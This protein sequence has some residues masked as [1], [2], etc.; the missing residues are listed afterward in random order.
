MLR[1][2][3]CTGVRPAARATGGYRRVAG[4]GAAREQAG[5]GD[6]RGQSNPGR[7]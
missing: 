1:C 5:V 3:V 6:Q 7:P 2:D 4:R